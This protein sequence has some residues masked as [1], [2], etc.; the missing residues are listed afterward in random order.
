MY[1]F[2]VNVRRIVF[3]TEQLKNINILRNIGPPMFI[4]W[5][6]NT[7]INIKVGNPFEF[8]FPRIEDPD[9]D[10][11]VIKI[12]TDEAAVFTDIKK[13]SLLFAPS[14]AHVS[15]KPYNIKIILEDLN[16]HFPKMR[17]N[18]TIKLFV[19]NDPEELT[20]TNEFDP[21]KE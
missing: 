6:D 16:I 13:D 12:E 11:Y 15:E 21:S 14:L 3:S 2:T 20:I 8:V 5:N 18:Y 17:S 1:Q 7:K 19:Y 10:D 4:D 9:D